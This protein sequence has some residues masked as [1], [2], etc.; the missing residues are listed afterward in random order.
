MAASDS[1]APPALGRAAAPSPRKPLFSGLSRGLL[2]RPICVLGL[3]GI[4]AALLLPR[5][6]LGLNTC[7]ML[8]AFSVP[9]PGCGLTRSVTNFLQG[10]FAWSFQYH[11]FGWGFALLFVALGVMAVLPRRAFEAA[12]ERASRYDFW[13]GCLLIGYATAIA[14]YGI[15]RIWMVHSG[16][17]DLAWWADPATP[18]PFVVEREG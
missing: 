14:V 13:I 17:P 8:V 1:S 9:C 2:I 7:S 5:T 10:N 11:P 12:V 18:P 6:G 4:L 16:N 3:V 15:V